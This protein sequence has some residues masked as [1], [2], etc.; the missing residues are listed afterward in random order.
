MKSN[1]IRT[2]DSVKYLNTLDAISVRYN[3]WL[4][5]KH[6]TTA[7]HSEIMMTCQTLTRQF[8]LYENSDTVGYLV[9][10]QQRYRRQFRYDWTFGSSSTTSSTTA[11]PHEIAVKNGVHNEFRSIIASK[12]YRLQL[13]LL[14]IKK[15]IIII[16]SV[17]TFKLIFILL[18]VD[19]NT[20]WN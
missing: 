13:Y 18:D 6:C 4:D 10:H 7:D 17:K 3:Q 5:K 11:L 12:I 8:A 16:K 20:L 19:A 2:I 15:K 14:H 1:Y 9:A